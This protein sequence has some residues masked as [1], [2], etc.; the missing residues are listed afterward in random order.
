MARIVI[1][2]ERCNQDGICAAECPARII[3][4]PPDGFPGPTADFGE[5][6]I[7]CG[8]CVAVCPTGAFSLDWMESDLCPQLDPELEISEAQ[9]V[10]FLLSRR[11]LRAFKDRP[12]ERAKLERL[13]QVGCQAPSAKNVQPWQWLVIQDKARVDRLEELMVGW[14]KEAIRRIPEGVERTKLTRTVGLCE[15]GG[16][17][18]LRGAPHLM[19]VLADRG[20]SYGPE[21]ATLALSYVTL[22]APVL[23]LGTCWSGYLMNAANTYRPVAEDLEIPEGLKVFGALMVGYPKFTY[24]R[25]P[26][27]NEPK[28]EWR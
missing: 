10:Q 6:C 11:S 3:E 5:A 7:R 14:L 9:A 16:Y 25:L 4:L 19:V 1:D 15:A 23:G 26:L 13:I 28:V 27:R 12:V 2:Q 20:W 18:L 24:H 8:H 17:R 22:L 21:D